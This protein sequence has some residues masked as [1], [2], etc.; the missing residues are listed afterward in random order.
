MP[1]PVSP[2]FF[3]L[4][5]QFP[6]LMPISL[7]IALILPFMLVMIPSF[8]HSSLH[9]SICEPHY[10]IPFLSCYILTMHILLAPPF[11]HSTAF[12]LSASYHNL[13]FPPFPFNASIYK[14]HYIPLQMASSLHPSI[15]ASHY[16]FAHAHF[17]VH[18]YLY[19]S[20]WSHLTCT[21]HYSPLKCLRCITSFYVCISLHPIFLGLTTN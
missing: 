20:L 5:F 9:P 10:A 16:T 19:I 12:F 4:S 14:S 8:L 1:S 2:P 6:H 21:C 7:F 11:M 13:P 18:F 17:Y 15:Y 3:F